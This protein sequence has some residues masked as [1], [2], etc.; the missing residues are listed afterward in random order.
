MFKYY[1][2]SDVKCIKK[3]KM[4]NVKRD[5][6]PPLPNTRTTKSVQGSFQFH[7]I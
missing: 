3:K 7:V 5:L 6:L 2:V 4:Y 1:K